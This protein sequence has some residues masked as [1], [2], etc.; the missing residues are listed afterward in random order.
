MKYLSICSGIE[1]AS[2]AF[3]PLGWEALAFSEIEPFPRAVLQ[4]HFPDVPLHSDFTSLKSEPWIVDADLLCGGTPCQAFSIAGERKSLADDRGNLSLQFIHLAD[5][6]DDLRRDAGRGPAWVLWENVPGVL[7]T[8]DN[9]FGHFLGG[10]CGHGAAIDATSGGA[11]PRAGV[12]NGPRRCAAWRVLDAQYFGLAQ[13]RQ[14]VFVL[15]LGG[16][17]RWTCADALLPVTK[18]SERRPKPR[19]K[20]GEDT[21]GH[22]PGGI[23]GVVKGIDCESN[24]VCDGKPMG[25]LTNAHKGGSGRVPIIMATGQANAEVVSDGSPSLNCN[26]EQPIVVYPMQQITSTTCRSNPKLGDP[27]PTITTGESMLMVSPNAVRRLTPVECERLQ[28]F[29]DNWTLVPFRGKPAKD[30][31][32]YKAIGNSWA[33]PVAR[34]IGRQ[35]EKQKR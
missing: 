24:G 29:P 23:G 25:T 14:R 13:R 31:P 7:N 26:H 9:A 15:A 33:V 10:L 16:A 6:I 30:G 18:S 19:R 5:A 8:P 35:M 20:E 28:G 34:W 17:G 1:A 4:H 27:S 11:W 2:V 21:P 32:R 22:A 3:A 12:A